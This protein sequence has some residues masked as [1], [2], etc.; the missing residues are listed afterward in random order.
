MLRIG[1]FTGYNAIKMAEVIAAGG[2]IDTIEM[3]I[4]YQKIAQENFQ[5]YGFDDRIQLIKANA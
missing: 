1:T 5:K 4:Q 2:Q 3:N